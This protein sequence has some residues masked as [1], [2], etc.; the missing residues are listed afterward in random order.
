MTWNNKYC[1]TKITPIGQRREKR[2]FATKTTKIVGE[3]KTMN[4][5]SVYAIKIYQRRI[6]FNATTNKNVGALIGIIWNV[7]GFRTKTY[8]I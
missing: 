2:D 7:Q 4:N 8:K 5:K 6:G 1:F 3:Q